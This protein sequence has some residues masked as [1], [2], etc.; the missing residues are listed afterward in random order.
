MPCAVIGMAHAAAGAVQLSGHGGVLIYVEGCILGGDG[1]AA[2]GCGACAAMLSFAAGLSAGGG[3]QSADRCRGAG[4]KGGP[5]D[6]VI[7]TDCTDPVAAGAVWYWRSLGTRASP[8]GELAA[9]VNMHMVRGSG[10]RE[11]KHVLSPHFDNPRVS[12]N[13]EAV[14]AV[15]SQRDKA[16]AGAESIASASIVEEAAG[17]VCIGDECST[18]EAAG[19]ASTQDNDRGTILGG[20]DLG[21]YGNGVIVRVRTVRVTT[22]TSCT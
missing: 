9:G 4:A 2:A 18:E 13:S 3:G 14:E 19:A 17:A 10:T 15:E 8:C 6:A 21:A 20:G 1:F 5:A 11:T 12:A 16:S 7:A 22:S